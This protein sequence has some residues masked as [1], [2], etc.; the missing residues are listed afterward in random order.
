[1]LI[2]SRPERTT[3]RL[4]LWNGSSTERLEE[5]G[6]CP[7]VTVP[8]GPGAEPSVIIDTVRQQ[9]GLNTAFMRVSDEQLVELEVLDREPGRALGLEWRR[10]ILTPAPDAR[11]SWHRPGWLNQI[12]RSADDALSDIGVART[13]DA[14]QVRHTSVTGM[15]RIATDVGDVW[16]K[17]L[18]P[19]FRHEGPLVEWLARI[20]PD[21]VPVVLAHGHEWWLSASFPPSAPP[22]GDYLITMASLQLASIDRLDELRSIGCGDRPAEHLA[23]EIE[24]IAHRHD[25]L[26]P[27]EGEALRAASQK[28]RVLCA[29]AASLGFPST[30]VHGDLHPGNVWHTKRGWLLF[31]WTDACIGHP[32]VDLAL[33]LVYRHCTG[34]RQRRADY[35][36]MWVPVVG[37]DAVRRG[38]DLAPILGVA[39]EAVSY[40]MIID[41]IDCSGADEAGRGQ[42]KALLRFWVHALLGFLGRR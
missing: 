25:L 10:R 26:M 18:P 19:L 3:V 7:T 16:L 36:A 40:R 20:A 23:T 5:N 14:V 41:G 15:L 29:E 39:H 31:D 28:L 1:M 9:L 6:R 38:L 27:E 8:G 35:G 34:R 42:L 22:D 37:E 4:G 17:A 33:P 12:L 13:S 24:Q 11:P 30:L 32:L 21:A 2:E